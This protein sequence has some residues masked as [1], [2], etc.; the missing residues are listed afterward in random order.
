MSDEFY[1]MEVEGVR[2]V[3]FLTSLVAGDA[4]ADVRCTECR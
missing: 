2:L 1:D 4:P 3:D